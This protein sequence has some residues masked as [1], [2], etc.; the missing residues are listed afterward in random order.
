MKKIAELKFLVAVETETGFDIQMDDETLVTVE[1]LTVSKIGQPRFK[2]VNHVWQ[3]LPRLDCTYRK[4]GAV[5]FVY[6]YANTYQLATLIM[7][8]LLSSPW[9]GVA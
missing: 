1:Q 4:V 2:I 3:G 5:Q 6:W 8:T 7:T 9:N